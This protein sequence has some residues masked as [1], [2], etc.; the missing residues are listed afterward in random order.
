VACNSLQ[1]TT[2]TGG[3]YS[4]AN[5]PANV[6]CSLT[7][8]KT[9]FT[10]TP[11]TILIN[12]LTA[13]ENGQ[14][15]TAHTVFSISGTVT[16]G[17]PPAGF[18]GVTVTF[19]AFNATTDAN[20]AYTINS[21]P[22]GSSARLIPSKTGYTFN[23]ASIGILPIKANLTGKNFVASQM[24][25][26]ISGRILANGRGLGG[27]KITTTSPGQLISPV[28]TNPLGYYVV[29]NL[30]SNHLYTLTPALIGY[31]IDPFTSPSLV[32][33]LAA[34]FTATLLLE[35]ISGTVSGLGTTSI[36]IRYGLGKNQWASTATD[37]T[38]TYSMTGLPQNVGYTLV[39]LNTL[40]SKFRFK[41]TFINIPAGNGDKSDAYFTA[42]PQVVMSG[43]VS[44]QNKALRGIKVSAIGF[45]DLFTLTDARGNYSLWVPLNADII[46]TAIDPLNYY[47]FAAGTEKN[48]T[49]GDFTQNWSSA[50]VTVTGTVLLLNGL[51]LPNVV[52]SASAAK[53]SPNAST[54][55]LGDG[56]YSLTVHDTDTPNLAAFA[57]TPSLPSFTPNGYSFS[58]KFRLVKVGTGTVQNFK[59][60]PLKW[61]VSGTI[62]LT[63]ANGPVIPGVAVV[64]EID[65]G[66]SITSM[67]VFTNAKGIFNLN[68]VPYNSSVTLTPKKYGYTFQYPPTQSYPFKMGAGSAIGRNFF[69]TAL[70]ATSSITGTITLPGTPPTALANVIVTLT[71]NGSITGDIVLKTRTAKDG[72]YSFSNLVADSGYVVV[73]SLAYYTFDP[74]SQPLTL[75]GAS[76]TQ[77]FSATRVFTLSGTIYR[78]PVGTPSIS[79]NVTKNSVLKNYPDVQLKNGRYAIPD[80]PTGQTY[81]V[82]PVLAGYTFVATLPFTVGPT[83]A[84]VVKN[85]VAAP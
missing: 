7:P 17:V 63:D 77:D 28:T 15:F 50:D 43:K 9:G 45:P 78:L 44:V 52:I 32:S 10:F 79:F 20:G 29:K 37:G 33:N 68:G 38:E 30:D 61:S 5:V 64:A 46:P 41:P 26:T 14:N 19:G 58:P 3:N 39:P 11:A 23:P 65:D 35:N 4:I 6:N 53:G 48:P 49:T 59:A 83:T 22:S 42:T 81:V 8:A 31:S 69:G 57:V 73:P 75:S 27:V 18:Q 34:N 2:D 72:T 1:A 67:T 25:F 21:I 36:H 47:T 12:G 60:I 51:P 71:Y 70:P 74:A 40:T 62:K 24:K 80:L 16:M 85:F 55:T 84:V 13:D 54:L 76:K 66:V 82:V 56:S